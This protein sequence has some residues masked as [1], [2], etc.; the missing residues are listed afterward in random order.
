[1]I[2]GKEDAAN[3]YARG[4][5]TVGKEI[6]DVIMD[7]VRKLVRCP[8]LTIPQPVPHNVKTQ[9]LHF[10]S[11]VEYFLLYWKIPAVI[12]RQSILFHNYS[13]GSIYSVKHVYIQPFSMEVD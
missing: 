1:M 10:R 11:P 7:R 4:H 5:Y 13:K 12:S 6:I 3:N 8:I 9:Y 2:T